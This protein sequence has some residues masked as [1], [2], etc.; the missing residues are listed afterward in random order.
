MFAYIAG[1]LGAAVVFCLMDFVWLAVLAKNFYHNRIGTL[2]LAEPR[3]APAVAFYIL[4]LL[5][6]FVFA[7][8]P[9]LRAQNLLL[10]AGLGG[11]LGLIAYGSYDLT[12]LA[13]LKDW[14]ASLSFVD[15][16]WGILVS[17]V[18]STAGF[19]I[20]SMFSKAVA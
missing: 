6:L 8:T 11:L 9:A 16:A 3:L 19:L 17:A 15:I 10:A 14:S 1:Y 20:V 13:T 12:N 4:Y 7:V 2:M 18:S 5:G